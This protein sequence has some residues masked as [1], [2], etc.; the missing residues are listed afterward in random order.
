MKKKKFIYTCTK[1]TAGNSRFLARRTLP[2]AFS[3]TRV[4]FQ[5]KSITAKFLTKENK[6]NEKENKQRC[7]AVNHR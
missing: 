7:K 4:V 2:H 3:G 1:D 6:K 5:Q